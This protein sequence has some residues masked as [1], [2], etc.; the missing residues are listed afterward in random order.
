MLAKKVL[1][2][3]TVNDSALNDLGNPYVRE[4]VNQGAT[5][6][7][8]EKEYPARGFKEFRRL[9]HDTIAINDMKILIYQAEAAEFQFGLDFF[10]RYKIKEFCN[11]DGRLSRSLF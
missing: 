7:D 3:S 8:Y 10:E 1:V 5:F 9:V 11:D 2:I 6:I 4:L